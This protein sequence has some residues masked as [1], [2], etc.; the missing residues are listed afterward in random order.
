MLQAP[1]GTDTGNGPK[2]VRM[3]STNQK[4]KVEFSMMLQL[5]WPASSKRLQGGA[6]AD[7]TDHLPG[8][9]PLLTPKNS[10]NYAST[11]NKLRLAKKQPKKLNDSSKRR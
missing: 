11:R 2:G 6:R 9:D 10:R 7:G 8:L 3:D 1:P 5:C 4:G